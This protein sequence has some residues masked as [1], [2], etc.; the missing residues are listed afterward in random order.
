VATAFV[1]GCQSSENDAAPV[2][3]TTAATSPSAEPSPAPVP[4]DDPLEPSSPPEP[5]IAPLSPEEYQRRLTAAGDRIRRALARLA[6]ART[7]RALETRVARAESAASGTASTLAGLDPP[8]EA[9]GPHATLVRG[10]RQLA[11]ALERAARAVEARSLCA[12]SSTMARL[13][14]AR[15]RRSL[16]AAR[17]QLEAEGYDVGAL[18]PPRVPIAN[19]RLA[20]GQYVVPGDRSGLGTLTID[21]GLAVDSLVVL[22][23]GKTVA[24]SMYVGRRDVGTIGGIRDGTYRVFF[25]L[26]TDWDG[27]IGKFT[28]NCDFER[29]DET[30]SF[31]TSPTGG[32]VQFQTY[33]VTLHA[34]V[35]GTASTT[36]VPP[37]AFP[38]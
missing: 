37:D 29:F 20:T 28:R 31:E 6:E 36:D 24:M 17:R 13:G 7:F 9:A 25:T 30:V 10:V 35:G 4:A 16:G 23:V 33:T 2:Q 12:A 26:G 11:G 32:G 22:S 21:N 15:A 27:G 1:G 5:V 34:V 8:E 19:R 14:Q 3:A 38:G 18:M